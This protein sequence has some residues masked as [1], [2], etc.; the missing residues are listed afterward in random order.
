MPY[1]SLGLENALGNFYRIQSGKRE[2]RENENLRIL[3]REVA[4]KKFEADE[5]YR[6]DHLKLMEERNKPAP[7]K[8]QKYKT[9]TE[10][11]YFDPSTGQRTK[12]GDIAPEPEPQTH[13]QWKQSMMKQGFANDYQ[14]FSDAQY[15]AIF[16]KKR[17][18]T[19]KPD[20]EGEQ[21]AAFNFAEKQAKGRMSG[22]DPEAEWN[23]LSGIQKSQHISNISNQL[24][25]GVPINQLRNAQITEKPPLVEKGMIRDS[26]TP[27]ADTSFYPFGDEPTPQS[28]IPEDVMQNLKAQGLSEEEILQAWM[29]LS[30]K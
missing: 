2:A 12:T 24:N 30:K 6:A 28:E 5:K 20:S 27:Q 26:E 4:K 13:T 19:P 9:D 8:Y 11:G 3:E 23:A 10:L 7:T 25:A 22:D 17:H 14:D 21:R 18:D 29:D 16:G 1:G 15:Y